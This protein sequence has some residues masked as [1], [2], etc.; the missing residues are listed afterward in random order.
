MSQIRTRQVLCKLF[1][2][3]ANRTRTFFA[4]KSRC[5]S[6]TCKSCAKIFTSWRLLAS[7]RIHIDDAFE[8][9]LSGRHSNFN[10]NRAKEMNAQVSELAASV[11]S[12]MF[13]H[14][15]SWPSMSMIHGAIHHQRL[16]FASLSSDACFDTSSLSGPLKQTLKSLFQKTRNSCML[17]GCFRSW[18]HVVAR[19]DGRRSSN[20]STDLSFLDGDVTQVIAGACVSVGRLHPLLLGYCAVKV[21][22]PSSFLLV[23][24]MHLVCLSLMSHRVLLTFENLEIV[25]IL[26]LQVLRFTVIRIAV[27]RPHTFCSWSL[28]G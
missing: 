17:S 27:H 20:D 16:L 6:H 10:A 14:H 8:F 11:V 2:A 19:I 13:P 5:I 7:W 21:G 23:H 24:E 28:F 12:L 1:V 15:L 18:N 25:S 9:S 26:K 22:W 3:W 4:V